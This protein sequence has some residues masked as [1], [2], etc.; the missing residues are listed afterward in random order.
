MTDKKKYLYILLYIMNLSLRAMFVS[1]S[2]VRKFVGRQLRYGKHVVVSHRISLSLSLFSLFFPSKFSNRI[3]EEEII[4]RHPPLVDCLYMMWFLKLP[5]SLS[6][7][8]LFPSQSV[9]PSH[10]SAETSSSIFKRSLSH[11]AATQFLPFPC[12]VLFLRSFSLLLALVTMLMIVMICSLMMMTDTK[13]YF[14]FK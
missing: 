1:C 11:R 8:Y 13:K 7:F 5:L 4:Q 2:G 10:R 14:E 9:S 12:S 3:L 6:L